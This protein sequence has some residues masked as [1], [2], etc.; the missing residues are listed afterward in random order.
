MQMRLSSASLLSA[1]LLAGSASLAWAQNPGG[2]VIPSSS[3]PGPADTGVLVHTNVQMLIPPG[4]LP[5]VAPNIPGTP[6]PPYSGYFYETPASIGCI[7]QLVL[8]QVPGCNPNL[9]YMNPS[10]GSRAVAIVDA[11]HDPNATA[12]FASFS[13]QF[14]IFGG[15]F[16]YVQTAHGNGSGVCTGAVSTPI[17]DPTGGGWALEESL[18]IEYAHAMAPNAAIY[19]VEAQSNLLTDMYCAETTAAILVSGLGGGEVS[20]SWGSGEFSS[21]TFFDGIFTRSNVVFFASSGDAPGTEYPCT[22]PN[23]VCVGGTS[24]GRNPVSGFF[25]NQETGW[26]VAG[27]GPSFYESRPGYQ[28]PSVGIARAVPDV[29]ADANPSTGVWVLDNYPLT[30]SPCGAPCWFIVGGTSVASPLW[31]GIVNRAGNFYNSSYTELTH[32]YSDPSSDFNDVTI[33]SCGPYMGYLASVGWDFCT[34]RGSPRG[35]AGK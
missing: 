14:G 35:Y 7:Y 13:T 9:A 20:N 32:L 25:L 1:L 26:Q 8:P 2:I 12:D 23:V 16:T 3:V 5:T 30:G 18:D 19:L 29:S 27:G 10:G 15:S 28:P 6:G 31:A 4:G 22:S 21:E 24:T 11:Y 17:N 34:G 33:G